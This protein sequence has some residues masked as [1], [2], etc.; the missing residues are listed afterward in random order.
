MIK[1][2]RRWFWCF[3]VA[4]GRIDQGLGCQILNVLMR[5][6]FIIHWH[7][8]IHH[9]LMLLHHVAMTIWMAKLMIRVT[10]HLMSV[11]TFISKNTWVK[12]AG[13][14]GDVTKD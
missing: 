10:T 3:L 2:T 8:T 5:M 1:T 14:H 11:S 7:L 6:A 9:F 4:Q 12:H 13:D